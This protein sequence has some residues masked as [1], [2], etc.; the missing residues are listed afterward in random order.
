MSPVDEKS[1]DSGSA[2]IGLV[3]GSVLGVLVVIVVVV[4]VI[5]LVRRRS[6]RKNYNRAATTGQFIYVTS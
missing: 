5:V 4:V 2:P 6:G 3:V 1:S